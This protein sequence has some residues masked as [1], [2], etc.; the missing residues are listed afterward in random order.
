MRKSNRGRERE[1]LVLIHVQEHLEGN[2]WVDSI[3]K[4]PPVVLYTC[5]TKKVN[6]WADGAWTERKNK[7]SL[8]GVGNRKK[9]RKDTNWK[10]YVIGDS[11]SPGLLQDSRVCGF[12]FFQKPNQQ[13]IDCEEGWQITCFTEIK[14]SFWN[15]PLIIAVCILRLWLYKRLL[16]WNVW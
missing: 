4:C 1:S 11:F 6:F 15:F 5:S 3:V 16:T 2:F 14:F 12:L 9:P 8:L 10:A 13:E 7:L